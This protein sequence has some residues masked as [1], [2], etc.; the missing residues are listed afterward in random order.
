[1]VVCSAAVAPEKKLDTDADREFEIE[2][3]TGA[4]L[5]FTVPRGELHSF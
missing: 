5:L 4:K 3:T 2:E 1:V